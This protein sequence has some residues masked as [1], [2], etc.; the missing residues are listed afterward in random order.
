M[1]GI[2]CKFCSG[3]EGNHNEV[4]PSQRSFEEVAN[5]VKGIIAPCQS[6]K[7]VREALSK[8]G[9]EYDGS[10]FAD[11]NF[12]IS[13]IWGPHGRIDVEIPYYPFKA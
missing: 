3:T 6:T 7:D 1:F 4:C 12:V 10:L 5:L 11:G 9:F 13:N 2:N 8:A